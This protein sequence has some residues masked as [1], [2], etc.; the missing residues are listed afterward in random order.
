VY[1]DASD[2]TLDAGVMSAEALNP[3]DGIG[4]KAAAGDFELDA[5]VGGKGLVVMSVGPTDVSRDQVIDLA[6]LVAS[7]IK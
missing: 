3:V 5:L 7:R 1:P 2:F 4:D 6:K